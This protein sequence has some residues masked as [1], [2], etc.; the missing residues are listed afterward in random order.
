MIPVLLVKILEKTHQVVLV[1]MH[2][3]MMVMQSLVNL[4]ITD[5]LLV[6][7]LILNV[8]FVLATETKT[9]LLVLVLMDKSKLVEIV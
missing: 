1:Q 7:I 3:S 2:I 9:H 5:V 6:K 4:V 8:S